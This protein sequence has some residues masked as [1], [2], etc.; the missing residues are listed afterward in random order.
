MDCLLLSRSV[1]LECSFIISLSAFHMATITSS[2]SVAKKLKHTLHQTNKKKKKEH[3]QQTGNKLYGKQINYTH[4]YI[5][6]SRSRSS[7][8]YFAVLRTQLL[9]LALCLIAAPMMLI[10]CW[11][12]VVAFFHFCCFIHFGRQFACLYT[13]Q[14]LSL[15]LSFTLSLAHSHAHLLAYNNSFYWSN[16]HLLYISIN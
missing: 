12:F 6:L 9:A 16:K 4:T 11:V 8:L 7:T 15:F 2:A 1:W 3:T 13:E 5:T 10:G 14:K